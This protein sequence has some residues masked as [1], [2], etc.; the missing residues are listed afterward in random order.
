MFGMSLSHQSY[1]D[2]TGKVFKART[3][4][5]STSVAL[6]VRDARGSPSSPQLQDMHRWIRESVQSS[7]T[8]LRKPVGKRCFCAICCS[9][10]LDILGCTCEWINT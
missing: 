9:K 1:H 5:F 8:P 2:R 3:L 6:A 10:H 7:S 4:L